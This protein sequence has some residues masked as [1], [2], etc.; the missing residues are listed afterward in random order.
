LHSDDPEMTRAAV[1]ELL[2]LRPPGSSGALERLAATARDEAIRAAA[3]DAARRLRLQSVGPDV[4]AEPVSLP[5]VDRVQVSML[6]GSGTQVVLIVRHLAPEALLFADFLVQDGWGVKGVFGSIRAT[7]DVIEE[8]EMQFDEEATELVS[9][10]LAAARGVIDAALQENAATGHSVPPEFEF[11]EMHLHDVYPP[12][13]GE[14][15]IMPELD[16]APYAGR[17]DLLP[18]GAELP[19]HD[20]FESWEFEPDQVNAALA[21]APPPRGQWTD[22]QYRPLITRL[23]PAEERDRLRRNLCRQAWL[24]DQ[25]GDDQTR[26]IALATAAAMK[27]AKPSDL[28]KLPFLRHLVEHSVTRSFSPLALIDTLS[29]LDEKE[30]DRLLPLI[31]PPQPPGGR[32][33]GKR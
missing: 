22:R 23:V 8:F 31:L 21:H 26:D 5:P 24:L 11:W 7:P 33:R 12:P 18:A 3:I 13:A 14:P 4:S 2:R 6:D 32:R 29:D 1:R 15:V 28:V 27:E 17:R 9:V 10:D 16:D 20:A 30:L 19:D 25:T